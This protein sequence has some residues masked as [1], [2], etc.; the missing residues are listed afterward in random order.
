M[1]VNSL[2]NAFEVFRNAKKRNQKREEEYNCS[3]NNLERPCRATANRSSADERFDVL[4]GHWLYVVDPPEVK[5]HFLRARQCEVHV[6][7]VPAAAPAAEV[8]SRCSHRSPK[9]PAFCSPYFIPF[10]PCEYIAAKRH[11]NARESVAHGDFHRES[12]RLL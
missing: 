12:V 7:A 3:L 4:V 8:T 1:I 10:V 11:A 2:S 6:H 5:V 9:P